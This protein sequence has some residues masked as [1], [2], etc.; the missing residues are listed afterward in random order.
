M[1]LAALAELATAALSVGNCLQPSCRNAA[2]F[3]T[4]GVR[5]AR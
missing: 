3:S 5:R 1:M 2:A 4:Y